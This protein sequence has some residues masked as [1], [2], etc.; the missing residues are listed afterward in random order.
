MV[1]RQA[2]TR[3]VPTKQKLTTEAT[4]TTEKNT[5]C[6]S[7]NSVISVVSHFFGSQG[8][9]VNHPH[10]R[11]YQINLNANWITLG[12]SSRPPITPKV[13]GASEPLGAEN[14]T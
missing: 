3:A 9:F 2:A 14:W 4:E 1:S 5:S 12:G 11:L 10:H 6:L 13:P 7:V 8:R